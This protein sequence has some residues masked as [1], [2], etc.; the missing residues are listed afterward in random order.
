MKS[1][2]DR[3][4]L[5]ASCRHRR[6]KWN[7][8]FTFFESLTALIVLIILTILIIALA[9]HNRNPVGD[10]FPGGVPVKEKTTS[11]SRPVSASRESSDAAVTK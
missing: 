11:S 6:L 9:K 7:C 2:F 1:P 4:S 8:G 5:H 10:E 3:K